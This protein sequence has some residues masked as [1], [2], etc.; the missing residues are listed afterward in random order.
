MR[1]LFGHWPG[2]RSLSN[3]ALSNETG[4]VAV[5][6]RQDMTESCP[7]LLFLLFLNISII[8]IIIIISSSTIHSGYT[9]FRS[10]NRKAEG[11]VLVRCNQVL[12]E[13]DSCDRCWCKENTHSRITCAVYCTLLCCTL[14]CCTLLS[15]PQ[16]L[17]SPLLRS[18]VFQA[19]P[20]G[21]FQ[22]LLLG[23]VLI[24]AL[25]AIPGERHCRFLLA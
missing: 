11:L 3:V 19:A 13:L 17:S 18:L 6:A 2:N 16:L 12:I 10:N 14:L 20:P 24:E 7:D 23:T 1:T 15:S 5:K 25:T 8:I 22:L 21:G 4:H 9:D